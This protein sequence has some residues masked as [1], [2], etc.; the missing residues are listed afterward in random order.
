MGVLLLLLR[1]CLIMGVEAAVGGVIS[2]DEEVL[3]LLLVAGVI[4]RLLLWLWELKKACLLLPLDDIRSTFSFC[5]FE[6]P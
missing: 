4:L 5:T 6:E 2:R 1:N 3:E